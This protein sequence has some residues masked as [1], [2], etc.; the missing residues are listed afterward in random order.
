MRLFPFCAFSYRAYLHCM[1]SPVVLNFTTH[2]LLHTYFHSTTSPT[3][4]IYI[5]C[6][7]PQHLL[8]LFECNYKLC[9]CSLFI[10]IS[11][12]R[13]L[14]WPPCQV[15]WGVV[16]KFKNFYI[17]T[18]RGWICQKPVSCYCPFKDDITVI[19]LLDVSFMLGV[20]EW[21]RGLC[22]RKKSKAE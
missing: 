7:L 12:P 14:V 6:I 13:I 5:L 20:E 11:K 22:R 16:A 2:L 19:L 9:E 4:L 3:A 10:S 15:A 18:R 17:Q 21:K 8:S 1:P